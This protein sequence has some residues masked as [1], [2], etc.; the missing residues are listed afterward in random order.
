MSILLDP[1]KQFINF[2]LMYVEEKNKK[3]GTSHFHFIKNKE[4]NDIWINKGY[5]TS[6]EFAQAEHLSEADAKP[7]S[8]VKSPPDPDKVIHILRTWWS[9]ITW[10]EQNQLYARCLKSSTGAD[11]TTKTELDAIIYRDRKLKMCLKKWDFR[12][13]KNEEISI[14]ESVIDQ[15]VPQVA[16]EL[17]NQFEALTESNEEEIKN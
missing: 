6:D 8:P 4:E 16:Q 14:N 9:Q 1:D 13:D 7:G 17:L 12:N 2:Q 5:I 10:K 3:Y 15:L 11:G